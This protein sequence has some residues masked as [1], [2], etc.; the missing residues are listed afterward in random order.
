MQSAVAYYETDLLM[1]PLESFQTEKWLHLTKLWKA[2]WEKED[3]FLNWQR[4]R[5]LEK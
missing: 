2:G 4:D 5:K 1:E 3:T